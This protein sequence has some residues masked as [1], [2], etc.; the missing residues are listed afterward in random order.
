MKPFIVSLLILL[1]ISPLAQAHH[2]RGYYKAR[3]LD[4][5]PIY[6]YKTVKAPREVCYESRDRHRPHRKAIVVGSVIGG[7]IGHATGK[8]GN[9]GITTLAGAIIGGAVA[10]E[11]THDRHDHDSYYCETHYKKVKKVRVLK[12]YDVTYRY[13]G[14]VYNAFREHKP[15]KHIKIYY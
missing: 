6:R 9:K 15:G 14:R 4:V 3:V 12:G 2:S 11:L 1:F 8:R 7:T 10:N 5:T 13:K